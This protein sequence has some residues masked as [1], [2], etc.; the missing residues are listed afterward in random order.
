M[1]DPRDPLPHRHQPGLA[2][3]DLLR[4]GVGGVGLSVLGARGGSAVF[5]PSAEAATR[6]TSD[7]IL[8]V[9]E[10]SGAND[11]LNTV[12]PYADDAYYRARP[13]LG[14]RPERLIRLDDHVGL[15]STMTGLARLYKDGELAIVQ[16]VG[17][18]Q[19]SFS[20]F[21]SM[22]YWHTA[23][24]NSGETYG[25]LGRLAD[26]LDPK[27][28]PYCLVNVQARQSLAV[29]AREHVPL[30]FDDPEKFSRTGL[31]AEREV[32]QHLVGAT[33]RGPVQRF[34]AD[35]ARAA[36]SAELRVREAC[37]SYRT[38]VEYGL[39]RFG[40]ERVAAMIAGGFPTRVFY[41][42]YPNNAFDTHVY[43]A[44]THARLWKYTSDHIA[45]FLADMRR[46][47][48]GDDVALLM[49]SEFGRRVAE[50][51]N[52]GTD[53]GTAGPVFVV[54]GGVRGGVY[55]QPPDLLA[56]EDG[57]LRHT[58]DFR[59]VYATMVREWM[60]LGDTRTVLSD[61]FAGLGLYEA[62]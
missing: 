22:A 30:V 2:R 20:H 19:P 23:A 29:R 51:A 59:H 44:D 53:H 43:Q 10:L 56:L 15:Q 38:P 27:A 7:R 60:G 3:R 13:K 17:Y 39:Y 24:P 9:V 16:G 50:N 46:I 8:V 62:A 35:V 12:V 25:W 58:L 47:G 31:H 32:L 26:A 14:L 42:S 61:D 21:T 33:S 55:G 11:G 28:D 49:F 57:N 6:R 41:V 5:A 54:G 1:S 48:R 34:M 40:L 18:D 4:L 37:A 52:G 36:R 45:A